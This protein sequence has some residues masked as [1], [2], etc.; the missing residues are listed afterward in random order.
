METPFNPSINQPTNRSTKY[1]KE[2]VV[3]FQ[4]RIVFWYYFIIIWGPFSFS[5]GGRDG[6][7]RE[8]ILSLACCGCCCC[9]VSRSKGSHHA[10]RFEEDGK[11]WDLQRHVSFVDCPGHDIL[12]ATM[13]NGAA[14]GFVFAFAMVACCGGIALFL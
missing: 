8:F 12:M 7:G 11:T 3:L 5:D 13:L 1:Q 10:D 2:T 4:S 14:V 6:A 9:C